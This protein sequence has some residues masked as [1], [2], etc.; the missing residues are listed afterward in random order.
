MKE[1]TNMINSNMLDKL[2]EFY[3]NELNIIIKNAQW[4]I[5]NSNNEQIIVYGSKKDLDYRFFYI[6]NSTN[7][8]TFIDKLYYEYL[9]YFLMILKKITDNKNL[10]NPSVVRI[11]DSFEYK[12]FTDVFDSDYENIINNKRLFATTI[13]DFD[14]YS[15]YESTYTHTF[16]W[17]YLG[18]EKYKQYR[19]KDVK[20]FTETELKTFKELDCID[21]LY[22][23][24]VKGDGETVSLL[25]GL[26]IS[27][28]FADYILSGIDYEIKKIKWYLDGKFDFFHFKDNYSLVFYTN[29]HNIISSCTME[30]AKIFKD[31]KYKINFSYNGEPLPAIR[32]NN[33]S[34][35]Q[36]TDL[37]D[38]FGEERSKIWNDN[39]YFNPYTE[40]LLFKI[41]EFE[42]ESKIKAV[43]KKEEGLLKDILKENPQYLKNKTLFT[44]HFYKLYLKY[45]WV[46]LEI[47]KWIDQVVSNPKMILNEKVNWLFKKSSIITKMDK[48]LLNRLS[49]ALDSF[50]EK[51]YQLECVAWMV[52]F[53]ELDYSNNPSSIWYQEAKNLKI[54]RKKEL[55]FDDLFP[56]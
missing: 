49:K 9:D 13:I 18:K 48:D 32:D 34:Y 50:W 41:D 42:L 16:S 10:M 27:D 4:E 19:N 31:Y 3:P 39:H 21:K 5:V 30:I 45:P 7:L 38:R 20:D 8:D 23:D 47:N 40:E 51:N 11:K 53:D 46:S 54:I 12:N 43:D 37:I 29:D 25:T 2:K 24:L 28:I 14:I 56:I 36:I 6:S 55:N 1:N 52:I 22:R 17:A 26:P 33:I 35:K 44:K 15:M